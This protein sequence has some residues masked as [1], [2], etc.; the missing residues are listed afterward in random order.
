MRSSQAEQWRNLCLGNVDRYL[1]GSKA[2]DNKFK[3]FRNHVMHVRENYWGGAVAST[4]RW[5]DETV[6]ALKSRRWADAVYAAGVLSHYYTD[7]IQPLHTAQSEAEGVIH[8]ACE[9]SIACAYRELTDLL[10]SDLGGWPTVHAPTGADWLGQMVTLGAELAN[11]H[12]EACLTHY[13]LANGAKDPPRGLDQDLRIRFARL[14]GHAVVGYAAIMDRALEESQVKV[15]ATNLTLQ[16]VIATIQIPILWVTKKL[17]DA[18]ER[19][20]VESIYREYQQT[21]KVINALS[22]DDKA[23]REIHAAEVR[24]M[25]T[26]ELNAEQPVAV[27]SAHGTISLEQTPAKPSP[28]PPSIA[29]AASVDTVSTTSAQSAP[30]PARASAHQVEP[31][32]DSSTKPLLLNSPVS[33]TKIAPGSS[34]KSVRPTTKGPRYYLEESMDIERAPSI[35]PKSAARLAEFKI[36]S[37][38]DLLQANATELAAQI[39]DRNFKKE[40]L[41]EW[42]AQARL[43]CEVPN[44]RGH[45]AQILTAIGIESCNE[46]AKADQARLLKQA[47]TF[48]GTSAGQRILRG[49]SPPDHDEINDWITWAQSVARPHAA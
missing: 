4:K 41:E 22:D 25:T 43:C 26:A 14:I 19:A 48:V 18:K 27:G 40:I 34:A 13:N 49:G 12:Y 33:I 44:L 28:L 6:T 35:G 10:E 31:E 29:A 20:L 32:T 16:S 24:G 11:P 46:L 38:Y 2:P 23:V 36:K 37:V 5:Y 21:G 7:P 17:T 39:N 1:E 9:W 47:E 3:D 42:Q 45:D 8:Q 15:P 30:S